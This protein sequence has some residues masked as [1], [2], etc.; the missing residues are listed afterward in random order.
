MAIKSERT[1]DIQIVHGDPSS[2]VN[3]HSTE[4]T[5]RD[6]IGPAQ[7]VAFVFGVLL[8]VTGIVGMVRAGTSDL[9]G[10]A[11]TVGGLSMTALLAI[12]HLSLGVI[13][14]LGL[15]GT[16][17][18]KSSLGLV[19]TVLIIGGILALIQPMEA[20]GWDDTNGI[21][22]LISGL[23]GLIVATIAPASQSFQRRVI[24]R[25]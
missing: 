1:D 18:A 6:N 13:A 22:Y 7:I 5:W 9:T 17:A 8:T 4:E 21:A 20:M 25:S 16:F 14:L 3:E 2:Q 10:E 24:H 19:G 11:V 23:I 15:P 12:I